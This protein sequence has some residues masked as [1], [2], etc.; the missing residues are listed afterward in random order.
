MPTQGKVSS[1]E[2]KEISFDGRS[3]G[4]ARVALQ[5]R[6]FAK[7]PTRVLVIGETG[8][9]KSAIVRA[10]LKTRPERSV[11]GIEGKMCFKDPEGFLHTYHGGDASERPFPA[12][13]G[14]QPHPDR[15]YQ[16]SW[17]CIN[18]FDRL[19]P[20]NQIVLGNCFDA[21]RSTPPKLIVIAT[22]RYSF[23]ERFLK[24]EIPPSVFLGFEMKIFAPSL[25]ERFDD[26]DLL[27]PALIKEATAAHGA[28]REWRNDA[29]RELA[30]YSWPGNVHELASALLHLSQKKLST[31]VSPTEVDI[32]LNERTK[33]ETGAHWKMD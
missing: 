6:E 26:L 21:D 12:L 28:M 17:T 24:G 13:R 9:G 5:I 29:I 19:N 10:L 2:I 27:V 16:A 4:L 31:P 7:H 25:R 8:T 23:Y 20:V 11:Q 1:Q 18:R 14:A 32:M 3:D 15:E 30:K 22:A 33:N